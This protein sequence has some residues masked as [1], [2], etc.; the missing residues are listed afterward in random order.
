MHA[1]A[2][3]E[4]FHRQISNHTNNGLHCLIFAHRQADPDALC[5]AGAIKLL[6]E[7]SFSGAKITFTV[8]APQGASILGKQVSGSLGIKYLEKIERESILSADYIIVVDTGD[9]KLLEPYSQ[10]FI[11]SKATKIL[12]DH[13]SSSLQDGTWKDLEEKFVNVT[14]TSTCEIVASAFPRDKI[15]KHVAETLMTGL[16]FDSQHLGIATKETLEAAL[17]L[18]DAGAEISSAKRILRHEPDRSEVLGK[19]KAAQRIKFEEVGKRVI[20]RSEI[21]S[22]H[23]SVA[24]MLV[25]I[26]ADVGI[27]YGETNGEARLSVRSSQQFF[28]DTGIDLSAEIKKVSDYFGLTGGGHSTAAS[29]SGKIDSAVIPTDRLVQNI[30]GILLQK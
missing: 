2:I 11:D 26:G 20:A 25:E 22:F 1:D 21:S 23:A 5:S 4:L 30:K 18:V 9:P 13:H 12:V 19:I 16:L 28:R 8:V 10:D 24:R 29:L 17:I 7:S 14:S 15:S 3:L 6:L 27:A